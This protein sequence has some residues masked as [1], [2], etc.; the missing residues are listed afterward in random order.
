MVIWRYQVLRTGIDNLRRERLVFDDIHRK[1]AK[2]L[3]VKKKEMAGVIAH[4]NHI[5]ESREKVVLLHIPPAPPTQPLC[6]HVQWLM[7]AGLCSGI[8]VLK[9]L[10][11]LFCTIH[12]NSSIVLS[13]LVICWPKRVLVGSLTQLH[14]SI[15]SRNRYLWIFQKTETCLHPI[16]YYCIT[17]FSIIAH[18]SAEHAETLCIL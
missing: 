9:P 5:L 3:L 10:V 11:I 14:A 16:S 7:L 8:S 1:L 13:A 15:M 17:A 2:S 12:P 18:G 4:T 6:N